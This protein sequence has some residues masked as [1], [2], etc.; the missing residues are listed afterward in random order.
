M[1]MA[2]LWCWMQGN[3]ARWG[4]VCEDGK[5]ETGSWG[6][7]GPEAAS[8][9]IVASEWLNYARPRAL[10]SF[11]APSAVLST[12]GRLQVHCQCSPGELG[13]CWS[14]WNPWVDGRHVLSTHSVVCGA[15]SPLNQ[16]L[17]YLVEQ[18]VSLARGSR[19]AHRG[20]DTG[21]LAC[22]PGLRAAR[23]DCTAI[24]LRGVSA[25][26]LSLYVQCPCCRRPPRAARG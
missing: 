6:L 14:V 8:Q 19:A 22:T 2:P 7:L 12:G 3:A 1:R 20:H 16:Q 24:P 15:A 5:G 25:S 23:P 10:L 11:C 13:G 9:L 4:S 21:C 18:P 26:Q 17:L